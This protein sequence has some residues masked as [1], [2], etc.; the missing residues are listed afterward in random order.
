MSLLEV[1]DLR[2]TFPTPDG[3]LRAVRGVS[4]EVR[5]GQTLGVVG[6]SGSGKSVSVQALLGLVPGAR[7]EGSALFDGEQLIGMPAERLRRIRGARIGMV[8]QDPLSSLHP[9]YSVGRQI[10][11]AVLVHRRVGKEQAWSVARERLEQVGIPGARARDYP[12]QFSGGMRQRVMIAMAMAL[13]PELI[14]ADEPTTALD[15]TVRA[16]ILEL[17]GRLGCA[18]IVITHD[19]GVIADMA[20]DVMVMYAGKLV[21]KAGRRA[22]FRDP[23]HPYTR[24]LLNSL[25][26]GKER[27]TPI[28]GRPPSLLSP[29]GGCPF[30]PRCPVRIP[31]CPIEEPPMIGP[32][33]HP[34]AC[35]L[36]EG[37]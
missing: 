6:E 12:H 2:V 9:M 20:D 10:A 25:P 14:I 27:L 36:E 7:V 30:H 5:A 23:R 26:K 17:L 4:F 19:L 28:E 21:E 3:D 35:W 15:A 1:A 31:R 32:E 22:L 8:F 29:P 11:E 37:R 16:Q 13:D 24:G 18:L 34:D 33:D